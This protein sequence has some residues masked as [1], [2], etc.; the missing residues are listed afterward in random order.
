MNWH[1]CLKKETVSNK[2]TTRIKVK[3]EISGGLHLIPSQRTKD[4]TTLQSKKKF[5]GCC[6]FQQPHKMLGNN[7]QKCHQPTDVDPAHIQVGINIESRALYISCGWETQL[8][9]LM[10]PKFRQVTYA[11]IFL[12]F[13]IEVVI[14]IHVQ[15]CCYG[16]MS[17]AFR[18]LSM[19]PEAYRFQLDFPNNCSLSSSNCCS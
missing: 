17:C 4:S 16:D 14:I 9:M 13:K 19:A 12:I 2:Q 18:T 5:K 6:C 3:R 7:L 10:L 8:R 11:S 1:E 15:Y